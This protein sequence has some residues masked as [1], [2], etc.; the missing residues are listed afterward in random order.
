ME[1]K[2]TIDLQEI[3][4]SFNVTGLDYINMSG[5]KEKGGKKQPPAGQEKETG[6]KPAGSRANHGSIGDS[7]E[8]EEQ[9]QEKTLGQAVSDLK[10]KLFRAAGD[11]EAKKTL[12]KELL[13]SEYPGLQGW[14]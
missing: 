13:M 5:S 2:D 8:K 9:Q 3:F 7:T 12:L 4:I 11:D 1:K 6:R 10:S 14:R